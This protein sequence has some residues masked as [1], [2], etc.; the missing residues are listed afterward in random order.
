MPKLVAL[1]ASVILGVCTGLLAGRFVSKPTAER[2]P[3]VVDVRPKAESV[4]A[5]RRRSNF[6]W[7]QVESDDIEQYITNLRALGCSERTIGDI[8]RAKLYATYQAKINEVFNPLAR[9]WNTTAEMKAVDDQVKAIREERD[10][11]WAGLHL[12]DSSFDLGSSVPP[13]KQGAVTDAL[14]LYPKIQPDPSWGAQD[15]QAFLQA[16]KARVAYLAQYLTADELYAYRVGEDGNP[17]SVARLLSDI[18]PSEQEFRK[19]FEALDGE[20][21]SRTNGML[22]AGLQDKLQQALGADRYGQYMNQLSSPDHQ[23]NMFV[24]AESLSDDQVQQLKSL[25][26]AADSMN[27]TDYRNAAANILQ[28]PSAMQRFMMLSHKPVN[29]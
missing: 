15:W 19:V 3:A 12:E 17:S 20:D 26:A 5:V 18:S 22:A 11:L 7:S 14:K 2:R 9:Y 25:L 29:P 6:T 21:L 24:M 10:R 8:I 13:E 28:R 1:I 23:F 16:R 4:K 27:P